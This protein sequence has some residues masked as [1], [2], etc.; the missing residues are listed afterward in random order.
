[1]T[2]SIETTETDT[3]PDMAKNALE[4]LGN[5]GAGNAATS[6]SVMLSS[7]LT[8]SPPQVEICDF[9]TLKEKLGGA[10]AIVV[11]VLSTITGEIDA[12]ILFVLGLEDA[13]NLVR[14]LMGGNTEIEWHSEI[15]MSAVNEIANI[16]IGSYVSSLE[17]LTGLKIR[18]SPPQICIDMAGSILS[19]P[20]IEF[21]MV[22]DNALLINSQFKDGEHEING[23]I[24][25]LSEM[26]SFN[27]MLNK[28][29]IGGID[30]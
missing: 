3:M 29:G 27:T 1:M 5:I 18:Y 22:S 21:G 16:L 8:V 9:N 12:M 14:S 23:Y 6:L 19:V 2:D 20:C 4:E 10:E 24:M 11:G 26:H 15:G 30:E 13:E 7:G 17:T 28:L 25:L